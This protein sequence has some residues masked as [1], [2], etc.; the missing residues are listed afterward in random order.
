MFP[1]S[2]FSFGFSPTEYGYELDHKDFSSSAVEGHCRSFGLFV[3]GLYFY[4]QRK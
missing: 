3:D 1:F 4:D 2:N